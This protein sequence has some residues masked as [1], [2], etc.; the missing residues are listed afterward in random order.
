MLNE[1]SVFSS[2]DTS[3]QD[4]VED[5]PISLKNPLFE[6]F[7][8]AVTEVLDI[9]EIDTNP[10]PPASIRFTGRLRVD[11][12]SAYETLD[13]Q[14]KPL[15]YY[16]ALAT[17]DEGQHVV[18]AL[19]G[20]V[21]PVERP[22]WPHVVLLI[23]TILS[24][25]FVGAQQASA[26][27]GDGFF[28]L[29]GWP[30]AL[31][32]ILILGT[33]ELG[34]Y[35]AARRHNLNVSLPYFFP[36]PLHI[37]GTLGAFILFRE[38]MRNR[39]QLFDVGVAGPLAGLVVAI[40]VLFIGLATSDV[41]PLPK[42]ENYMLEGDSLFY[43]AA[44]Y[45]V[46]GELLPNEDEDVFINQVAWAGWTGLLL[47]ALNLIPAGQLDGGHIIYTLLGNRTRDLYWPMLVVMIVLSMLSQIWW[48][49]MFLFL[50]FG[51]VYAVPLDSI[52]PLDPRRRWLAYA[53]LVILVLVF[54]PMPL[55]I[56][57]VG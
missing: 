6:Q 16:A 56:I 21:K 45:V 50:L 37:F 32:M 28:L 3:P 20:R 17:N 57:S 53:A 11:S 4:S 40:P 47:T 19:K 51:R 55:Q 31:G 24:L 42:D 41:Q 9:Y 13:E 33:H 34:H 44:K 46:F 48:M 14:F 35:F 26:E 38:P 25:L 22:R 30:F 52:T 18:M 12:E 5:K 15:D 2:S 49:L 8:T 29:D 1:P 39:K 10:P 36:F 7:E 27:N 43:S 23:L 54:V